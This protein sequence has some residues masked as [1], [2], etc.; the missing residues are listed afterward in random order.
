ME[1]SGNSEQKQRERIKKREDIETNWKPWFAW[2][3]VKVDKTE[4]G[5]DI[6]MWFEWVERRGIWILHDL[7]NFQ[8]TLRL[9]VE[10]RGGEYK[11][12]DYDHGY[13]VWRYRK[14]E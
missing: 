10:S 1:W 3:P 6:K 2:Y 9:M 8:P 4:T 11:T 14:K 12:T 13:W 7:F 5:E